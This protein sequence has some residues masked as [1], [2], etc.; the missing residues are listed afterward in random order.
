MAADQAQDLQRLQVEL[1]AEQKK[2]VLMQEVAQALGSAL[3]LDRLLTLVMEKITRLMEADRSTLYLFSDDGGEL[4]SKVLQGGEVREIRLRVGEGIAGW[5]AA[6]GETVNIP[7]AYADTRFY[8][9]VDLRTGYRTRSILCMPMKNNHG[10]TIGVI[11]VLNKHDGPFSSEDEA[12]LAALAGQAGLAIE[13]SKLFHSVVAKNLDLIEAQDQLA[14]RQAELNILFEIEKEINAAL[15]LGELLDRLLRRAM[16]IVGAEAGSILLRE[17]ATDDLYFRS[18]AGEAG[19]VVKRLRVP[20]SHGVVGWV[21]THKRPLVVNDPPG[22][23]RHDRRLAEAIGY[24]PRNLLCAPLVARE[25]AEEDVLGVIEL[26]DKSGPRP[27]FNEEDLKLLL[28][29]AGQAS[30]AI[31]LARAREE[32]MNQSRLASIGQMLSG[33]LHDLKTP[34]TIVSGYAQLMAQIDDS[35]QRAEYVEHILRQFEHMSSMTKEVLAFARGETNVLVRKVFMH[36]FLAELEAHL[37]HELTGKG[38]TLKVE[39]G[40]RGTAYFDEQ[41]MLRLVHNI[42]RNAVQA[43]PGG[44]LFRVTAR[45]EGDRLVMEFADTGGGIPP[46]MEGRL[47]ELF[48]TSGKKEGTG[49]G[50]AIVKK[51]VDEHGGRISYE[52]RRGPQGGTTFTVRLPL[53]KPLGLA[54]TDETLIDPTPVPERTGTSD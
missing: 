8:P 23:P 31:E 35:V 29:I 19:E 52:T 44:G 12:L 33:V 21:A 50:L 4:W 13:N 51:I 42:A 26:L 5:V 53:E 48:A 38:V 30:R 28:L 34:M 41:K 15:D 2:L 10:A 18:A 45:T 46:E 47:F 7:D 43:M 1:R 3:D 49:L 54:A 40:Y 39:A 22:D 36:K 32:R 16:D 11:Q 37:K 24:R 25:G 6:S 14:A 27:D 9:A 20:M 17:R